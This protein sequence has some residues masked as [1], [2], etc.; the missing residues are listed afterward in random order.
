MKK[1]SAPIETN[2]FDDKERINQY[3]DRT[4]NH[5]QE[6]TKLAL[7]QIQKTMLA[8]NQGN[9]GANT[10]RYLNH[11]YFMWEFEPSKSVPEK[12]SLSKSIVIACLVCNFKIPHNQEVEK[13]QSRDLFFDSFCKQCMSVKYHFHKLFSKDEYQEVFSSVIREKIRIYFDYRLISRRQVVLNLYQDS[14]SKEDIIYQFKLMSLI[15]DFKVAGLNS[16]LHLLDRADV[17]D[18]LN[19]KTGIGGYRSIAS[20][21]MAC[22]SIGERMLVEYLVDQNIEFEKEPIYPKHTELNPSGLMRADFKVK[23]LWVEFAGMLNLSEYA[24]RMEKK[25]QLAEEL[26]LNLLI[27]KDYQKKDLNRLKLRIDEPK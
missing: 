7:D 10:V 15:P 22:L 9:A 11:D 18:A 17:L 26:G 24:V 27:L 8:I 19:Q 12:D 16:I 23:D 25:K 3:F 2:Y 5:I 13:S 6:I 1:K 4:L 20:N 21:G 14:A